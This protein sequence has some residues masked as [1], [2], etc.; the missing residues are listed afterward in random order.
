VM[1]V[2]GAFVPVAE[3]TSRVL[4]AVELHGPSDRI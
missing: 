2:A 1:D 3:S 4:G